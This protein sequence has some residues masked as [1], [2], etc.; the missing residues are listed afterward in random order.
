MHLES[1][2]VIRRAPEDVLSFVED[3]SNLPKWDRGVSAVRQASPGP[4]GIGSEFDTLAYPRHPGD[5]PEWG[6][7]SYRVADWDKAARFGTI[8]LTSTT[9]NAR[10]FKSAAW[11]TRVE[12]VPEGSRV[13]CAVDFTLRARY[14]FLAPILYAKKRAILADME[15][16][17]RVLENSQ[18]H[19]AKDAF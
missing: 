12:P 1:T 4:L 3:I 13:C 8:E 10:Y 9:G 15:A 18:R 19:Q 17:R 11:L 7:M 5:K 14:A 16:L 2:I 6:R